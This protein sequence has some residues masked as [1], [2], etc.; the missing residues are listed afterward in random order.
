MKNKEKVIVYSVLIIALI[1]GGYKGIGFYTH[2]KAYESTDDAQIDGNVVP[3][4]ARV[5]SYVNQIKVVE[6]QPVQAG[7]LIVLLDTLELYSKLNQISASLESAL[8]QLEVT[9]SAAKD[10][11]QAKNL[12][13]L[14]ME[15]PKTNLWKAQNEYKRYNE[16]YEQKLATPQQID[17]YKANLETAQSQFDIAKQKEESSQLQYQTALSQ[18]KVAEANVS[19]KQKDIEYAK[20]QLSY[21]KIYAPICGVIS[22]NSLQPGQLIQPGQPLMSIVQNKEIW[23][24]ANFKETQMQDIKTGNEVEIN[25]D[26]Y[27]DLEVKGFVESTGGA[28]GAKF[29]L[30]PP[31]NA[32]GN[33]VKVVQRI[34]VRIKIIHTDETRKQLKP[35][36]SVSVEVKK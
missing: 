8:A 25:V 23:V 21:T 14:S 11:L 2:Y 27:P 1:L 28:T 4:I 19:Q 17:T 7:D 20:L 30:L 35:G 6:N 29:S 34:P 10:A 36:L 22:K 32:S 24:T 13:S 18:V 31:D 16:L 12:A 26:A 15:I 9:K 5:G 3:V 33:F